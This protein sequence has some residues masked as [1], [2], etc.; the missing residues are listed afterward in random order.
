MFD[1]LVT[2]AETAVAAVVP[3]DVTRTLTDTELMDGV[4]CLER[5]RTLLDAAE[6]VLLAELDTRGTTDQLCGLRTSGWVARHCG[7]PRSKVTARIHVAAKLRTTLRLTEEALADGRIT[8][9]HARVLCDAANPRIDTLLAGDVEAELLD[10]A[11]RCTFRRWSDEVRHITELLDD[12]GPDPDDPSK[13][14]LTLSPML[15]GLIE[16]KGT[17]VGLNAE[18]VRQAIDRVADELAE[19]HRRDH[20]MT[21]GDTPIPSRPTLRALALVELIRRANT[22]GDPGRVG[23][24]PEITLTINTDDIG[25][26][27]AIT[28]AHTPTGVRLTGGT[29]CSLHCDLSIFPI[30]R[31]SLGVPLDMGREIRTA[32]A[33]QRRALAAR[34]GGCVIAGCDAHPDHCH[35]HHIDHWT[36]QLG[37]T[38][39]KRMVLLCP[40]HHSV[41]HRKGW[42]LDINPDSWT[43]ITTPNGTVIPGQRHH[44]TRAGPSPPGTDTTLAF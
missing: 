26:N 3:G 6:G 2:D 10:L 30:V 24:S 27:G 32:T 29:M 5:A 20:Q 42:R 23:P 36:A 12:D 17:L 38:D 28:Q 44:T 1:A 39:V 40:H 14:R 31:D 25:D 35:A 8:W 37:H 34:D 43:T 13:N 11:G 41:I 4:R 15:H 22:A 21:G 19:R 18:T 7:G 16:L 9:D 33:H